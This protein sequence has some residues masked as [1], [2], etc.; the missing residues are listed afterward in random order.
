MYCIVS[1]ERVRNVQA[2]C[3]AHVNHVNPRGIALSW[4]GP[5]HEHWSIAFV[6]SASICDHVAN[7]YKHIMSQ[8]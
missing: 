8:L 2:V 3:L 4:I 1:K 7:H 5:R 6:E